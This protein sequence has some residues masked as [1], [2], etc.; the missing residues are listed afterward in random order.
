MEE[1]I[2]ILEDLNTSCLSEITRCKFSKRMSESDKYRKGR[3]DALNWIRYI[4]F[5]F[6]Q[7]EK[8]L[9]SEFKQHIKDQKDVLFNINEGDYKNAIYDQLHDIE[10]KLNKLTNNK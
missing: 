8:N 6:L 4:I 9:I 7:R 10:V 5:H 1:S 2:K 3:L